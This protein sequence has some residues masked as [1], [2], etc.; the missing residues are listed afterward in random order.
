MQFG[1]DA[2]DFTHRPLTGCGVGSVG[3]RHPDT[4]DQVGLA[5]G[6]VQLG[7]G[8]RGLVEWGAVQGQP[9][10]YAV[11]SDGLHFV[12]D[13]DVGVQVGVPGAGV[14]VIERGGDQPG[15]VDLGDTVGAHAGK[16]GVLLEEGQRFGDCLV[17]AVLDDPATL[18]A[19]PAPT[20]PTRI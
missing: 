19:A 13:R 18:S 14:A 2:D 10:R 15:G 11:G 16:A 6:V 3:E 8:D 9:A 12:A 20:A 7:G 17:V 4:L 5:A 1:G